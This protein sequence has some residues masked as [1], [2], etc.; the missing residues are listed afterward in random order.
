LSI[1]VCSNPA[2]LEDVEALTRGIVGSAASTEIHA[3]ARGVAEAQIDLCRVRRARH[4]LLC[5]AL[6]DPHY[7]SPSVIRREPKVA[8]QIAKLNNRLRLI[9]H[10]QLTPFAKKMKLTHALLQGMGRNLMTALARSVQPPPE[11]PQKLATILS[12]LTRRLAAL[13]RYER[14][15]LSRRKFAI[16]AF[17]AARQAANVGVGR[18]RS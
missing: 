10:L 16:R 5:S 13:D 11:G 7:K 6:S 18:S 1:P 15:A 3:L 12:D 4:D 2:L 17:D 8:A 14:R 9:P